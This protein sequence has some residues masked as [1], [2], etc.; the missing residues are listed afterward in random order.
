MPGKEI[1]LQQQNL[2]AELLKSEARVN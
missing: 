1:G 2:L